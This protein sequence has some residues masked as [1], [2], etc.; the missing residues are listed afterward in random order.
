MKRFRY[1]CMWNIVLLPLLLWWH[2]PRKKLLPQLSNKTSLRLPI[3]TS[4]TTKHSVSL[5]LPCNSCKHI[6]TLSRHNINLIP[7]HFIGSLSHD[8]ST[9]NSKLKNS[10]LCVW[11]HFEF[12]FFR[13][14]NSNHLLHGLGFLCQYNSTIA[15]FSTSTHSSLVFGYVAIK[16]LL[17]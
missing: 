11:I 1:V 4:R 3:F 6:Y 2:V 17:V 16:V 5:I 8:Q 13:Q 7:F 14:V 9:W 15:M 12:F 10:N